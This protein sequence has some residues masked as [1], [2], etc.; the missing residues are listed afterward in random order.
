MNEPL[1]VFTE[2]KLP[3]ESIIGKKLT[4]K[5][6]EELYKIGEIQKIVSKALEESQK[7]IQY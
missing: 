6:F 7:Y 2:Y 4:Y 5:E 1:K 3:I